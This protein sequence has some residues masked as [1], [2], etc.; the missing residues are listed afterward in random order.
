MDHHTTLT[1]SEAFATVI[2]WIIL[3]SFYFMPTIIACVRGHHNQNAVAA[4]NFFLGWTFLGWIIAFVWALTN[5]KKPE[6]PTVIYRELGQNEYLH[7][8]P[9]HRR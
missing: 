6:P 5:E 8:D 2:A 9:D 3:L 4:M 1:G 7:R